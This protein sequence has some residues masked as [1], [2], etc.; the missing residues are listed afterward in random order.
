[1]IESYPAYLRKAVKLNVDVLII[2]AQ[3]WVEAFDIESVGSPRTPP[4]KAIQKQ[5]LPAP[6]A[7]CIVSSYPWLPNLNAWHF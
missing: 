7:W 2:L 5:A 3:N 4:L 6:C 1:M